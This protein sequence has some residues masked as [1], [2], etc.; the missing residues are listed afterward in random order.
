MWGMKLRIK[1][2]SSKVYVLFLF[3]ALG[4]FFGLLVG[5]SIKSVGKCSFDVDGFESFYSQHIG[6]DVPGTGGLR[7]LSENMTLKQVKSIYDEYKPMS[8][9][10]VKSS[11]EAYCK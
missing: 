9:F 1:T 3:I 4:F 6:S 2:F 8:A 5:Y 7:F 10:V 11:V